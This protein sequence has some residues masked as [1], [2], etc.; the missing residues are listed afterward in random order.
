MSLDANGDGKA[1]SP[2]QIKTQYAQ[3][4]NGVTKILRQEFGP[5][6]VLIA[7]TAGEGADPSLNGITLES[8]ACGSFDECRSWFSDQEEIGT[9][10]AV[11]V[12]WTCDATTPAAVKAQCANAA[13]YQANMSWVQVGSAWW[14]GD[15]VLCEET[16]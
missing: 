8:E 2:A 5:G 3:W 6:A 9:Q 14:S 10:P 4:R 15:R 13:R 11:S 12:I 1:D 16:M 7:N